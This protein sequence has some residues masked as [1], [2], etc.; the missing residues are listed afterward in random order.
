LKKLDTEPGG[1]GTG[2]PT[3]EPDIRPDEIP[4]PPSQ[5]DIPV[6]DPPPPPKGDPVDVPRP[7]IT[8]GGMTGLGETFAHGSMRASGAKKESKEV[9]LSRVLTDRGTYSGRGLIASRA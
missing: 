5:P 8:G 7:P 1:P 2:T 6:T 4:P 3:P 9:E